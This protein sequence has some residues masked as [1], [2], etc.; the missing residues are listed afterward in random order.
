MGEKVVVPFTIKGPT[1][2]HCCLDGCGGGGV[3]KIGSS[4]IDLHFSQGSQLGELVF[5]NFYS[6]FI[7]VYVKRCAVGKSA[8][9]SVLQRHAAIEGESP[10]KS[11]LSQ[12]QQQQKVSFEDPTGR[13]RRVPSASGSG[14]GKSVLLDLAER[15]WEYCTSKRL[16]PWPHFELGSQDVFSIQATESLTEW[17]DVFVMR[18]VIHQPSSVWKKFSLE[19]INIFRNLSTRGGFA[20]GDA[21]SKQKDCRLA[22]LTANTLRMLSGMTVEPEQEKLETSTSS[23]SK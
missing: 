6:A 4:I 9:Q 17:R 2:T 1:P 13:Y 21:A 23:S 14:R 12:Q 5:T 18:L 15:P 7:S 19:G 22:A 20:L 16:M 10:E 8:G 11:T 3:K